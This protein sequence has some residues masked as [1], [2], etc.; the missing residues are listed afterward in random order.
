MGSYIGEMGILKI[1]NQRSIVHKT[2]AVVN[3]YALIASD[4]N[5]P[6]IILEYLLG[7]IADKAIVHCKNAKE[8]LLRITGNENRK[9]KNKK[10]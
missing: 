1:P 2:V 10:Q 5:K 7:C 8:V 3:A 9:K 4:P 6:V